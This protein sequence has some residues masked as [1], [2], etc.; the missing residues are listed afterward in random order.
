MDRC[1]ASS[2]T[3]LIMCFLLFL[4]TF[5]S[6]RYPFDSIGI[7][8]DHTNH[9]SFST[10]DEKNVPT[11]VNTN[12]VLPSKKHEP[13]PATL[14][15]WETQTTDSKSPKPKAETVESSEASNTNPFIVFSFHSMD[16][17]ISARPLPL[18]F[19]LCHHCH[20]NHYYKPWKP[21]LRCREDAVTVNNVEDKD[22]DH[23]PRGG[24]RQIPSGW[25]RFRHV[26]PVFLSREHSMA[27]ERSELLGRLYNRRHH[28]RQNDEPKNMGTSGLMKRIR[29]FLK[30]F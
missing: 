24:V 17:R 29:K 30:N 13:K 28:H 23:M 27:M 10:S 12:I 18:S 8:I 1:I 5:A 9:D 2:S 20:H 14:I 25:M 21:R 7:D 15:Q 6:A 16:P 4:F 11:D 22:Y 19:R 3:I 26:E